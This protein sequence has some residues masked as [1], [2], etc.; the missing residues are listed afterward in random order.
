M[1]INYPSSI[2][3]ALR[4]TPVEPLTRHG[5]QFDGVDL[6]IK[7]DDLTGFELSGNKV[8]KLEFSMADA[9]KKPIS[10]A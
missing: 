10:P 2:K 4:P 9:L 5:K 6:W 3:R 7:R 8:R 1:K